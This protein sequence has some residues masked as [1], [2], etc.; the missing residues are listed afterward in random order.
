MKTW[1]LAVTIYLSAHSGVAQAAIPD[2]IPI[3]VNL[4][5]CGELHFQA[6]AVDLYYS[7][8]DA[9]ELYPA[10]IT[11]K[12]FNL[13]NNTGYVD[14]KLPATLTTVPMHV[15][16]FCRNAL[17]FSKASNIV[18]ISN[19]DALALL[20][21]DGD[22]IPNNLEDINCNNF[23]DPT[24]PS[25]LFNV[26]T[27]G[28][29]VRDLVEVISAT[30]PTNPGSSPR[31]FVFAGAPFDP[32]GDGNSNPLAW[33][34]SSGNWY[35][36][37]FT[38]PGNHIAFQ[39]GRHGDIPIVYN[40]AGGTS[41]VG[42]VRFQGTDLIWYLRGLGFLLSNGTRVNNITFGLFGDNIIQGPWE[43]PGVTNPAVARLFNNAWAFFI[44]TKAGTIKLQY[45]GGDGDIP[46][47]QDF[48]GDGIF[49]IAVF[50]PAD[51]KTYAIHSSDN[52]IHIY[53]FGTG[54]A[55]HTVRGDY[56][57]DG[58]HDLTFWEP[59]TGM[60]TT[61]KSDNGFNDIAA[62]GKNPDYYKELQ[63]GLFI[64][65]LPLNWN[66][67][68]GRLLY[69]VIDHATG[70]RYWRE[71]NLPSNPPTSIQWGLAGDAYM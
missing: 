57:G 23:F 70:L 21:S 19:C 63:L 11:G 52:S 62:A 59:I 7:I 58:I 44:Y 40:P 2:F 45:W 16:A 37:D 36:R 9:P 50:R 39:Y 3:R 60:Y 46:K 51:Q 55:D 5:L 14:A 65:H 13:D 38:R 18:S 1:I 8:G 41:N 12:S 28:D 25:N 42:V 48:D 61:L 54:T 68:D 20:D 43:E 22:G 35:V 30:S 67:K 69:T 49:D 47:V 56:T 10:P 27:D 24:D 15:V 33:R 66:Q 26:D 17:G 6:V 71:N 64:V 29:G 32:D 31:P 53:N 4:E 34:P